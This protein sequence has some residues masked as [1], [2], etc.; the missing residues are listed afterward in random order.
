MPTETE[1]QPLI[2]AGLLDDNQQFIT[3]RVLALCD[4]VAQLRPLAAEVERLRPLAE[5]GQQYRDTL[6]DAAIAEGVRAVGET[7]A[8]ETYRHVLGES[9]V[10][11]IIRL[12][13]DWATLA[14]HRFAGGRQSQ[15][16]AQ[17]QPTRRPP[18]EADEAYIT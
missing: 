5:A 8:E 2:E 3:E 4:E 14:R 10:D 15:E 17:P 18:A 13:D 1:R 12:R 6:I 7:F 9:E 16:E 11:T